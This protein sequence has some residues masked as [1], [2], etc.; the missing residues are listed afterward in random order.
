[1]IDYQNRK[2]LASKII[3]RKEYYKWFLPEEIKST[4]LNSA[5]R[6]LNVMHNRYSRK[7]VKRKGE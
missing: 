2:T 7:C 5:A 4:E 3:V 1:M 6:R